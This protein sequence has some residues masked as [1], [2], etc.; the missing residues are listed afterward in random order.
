M[1]EF[2]YSV[3]MEVRAAL[4]FES[5]GEDEADHDHLMELHEIL[6]ASE[7]AE[8]DLIDDDLYQQLRFDLCPACYRKFMRNPVGDK[9]TVELNFSEN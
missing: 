7:D 2:R 9:P 1:D 4:D 3:R 5:C 6:E 8:S